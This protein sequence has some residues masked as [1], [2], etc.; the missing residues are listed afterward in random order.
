VKQILRHIVCAALLL[1]TFPAAAD[2]KLILAAEDNWYPYSA[3]R[4]GAPEGL[5]VDLVR[6]AYQAA[7]REVNLVS[8]PYARCLE[9]VEDGRQ[10]GC[11]DTTREPANE[12]RFLFHQEPLFSANIVIVAR[13]ESPALDLTSADLRGM[14]VAVTNGYTYGEPFQS[15]SLVKKDVTGS[16]LAVLRLVAKRRATYGVIYDQVMASLISEHSSELAGQIKIVGILS[17]QD[18]YVSFSRRRPEAVGAIAAL[19]AGLKTIRA[20]GTYLDIV[21]QWAARFTVANGN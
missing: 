19:D 1:A 15:D 18:L 21:Q 4:D 8:L 17:R 6:A 11:F 5:A 3:K 9:E 7:G 14:S 12:A 10:L 13:K 20:N 2:D 16:D